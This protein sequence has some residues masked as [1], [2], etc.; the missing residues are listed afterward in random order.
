MLCRV[1]F[2]NNADMNVNKKTMKRTYG[3]PNDEARS[4]K[5]CFATKATKIR[6]FDDSKYRFSKDDWTEIY[7]RWDMKGCETISHFEIT[8]TYSALNVVYK[9]KGNLNGKVSSF[10]V[11]PGPK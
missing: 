10:M 2:T 6:V 7:V 11:I 9:T 1:C 3:C 8:K 4:M 5:V